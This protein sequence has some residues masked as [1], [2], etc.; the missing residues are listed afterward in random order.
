MDFDPARVNLVLFQHDINVVW[1]LAPHDLSIVDFV[2]EEKPVLLR[3]YGVSHAGNGLENIGY[4]SQLSKQ[5][6]YGRG[7]WR[8]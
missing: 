5:F 2:V 3:A 6:H 8:L 1:D 7:S 4:I